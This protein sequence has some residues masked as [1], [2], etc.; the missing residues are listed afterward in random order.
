[1]SFETIRN[2]AKKPRNPIP[3]QKKRGPK[4]SKTPRRYPASWRGD[5]FRADRER[6]AFRFD[7]Y[8]EILIQ[9]ELRLQYDGLTFTELFAKLLRLYLSRDPAIMKVVFDTQ[10][11]T[12][13]LNKKKREE[14]KTIDK[15]RKYVEDLYGIGDKLSEEDINSIFDILAEEHE[16]L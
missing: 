5:K 9:A 10:K 14:S 1:M 12:R 8:P 13:A 7:D 2:E 16:D 15:H 3:G 6:R 4:K 11:E